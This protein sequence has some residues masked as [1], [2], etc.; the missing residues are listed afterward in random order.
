MDRDKLINRRVASIAKDHG[1]S[2]EEVLAHLDAHPLLIN[3]TKY[4]RRALALELAK[5]DELEEAFHHKAILQKDAAAAQILLK[6]FE[7]RAA[8]LGL[9]R[10]VE[11]TVAM[12]ASESGTGTALDR[13]REQVMRDASE[14]SKS[15]DSD[16]DKL[17]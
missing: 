8:L 9:E 11:H 6:C 16:D 10:P 5:L 1:C 15:D 3:R 4:T 14:A 2:T 13:I 12:V 17:N 7:R